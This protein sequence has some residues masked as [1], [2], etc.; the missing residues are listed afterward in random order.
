MKRRRFLNFLAFL[1]TAVFSVALTVFLN[2]G[3]NRLPTAIESMETAEPGSDPISVLHI[4]DLGACDVV[5]SVNYTPDEFLNPINDFSGEIIDIRKEKNLASRG[6]FKF[7]IANLDP[8]DEAFQEKADALAPFLSGDTYWHFTLYLP[9]CFSACA[10]YINSILTETIGEI[11]DYDY[12]RYSDYQKRT[13]RHVS[14]TEPIY[15][16]LSF[17]PKRSVMSPNASDRIKTVTIHYET[18]EGKLSGYQQYPLIGQESE[19][20]SILRR[21]TILTADVSLTAAFVFIIFFFISI[22][23]KM[24]SFIP[25]LMN[26]G[27]LFLYFFTLFLSSSATQFPYLLA[28][29]SFVSLQIIAL[30]AI[31]SQ[32]IRFRNVP[33]WIPFAAFCGI[34]CVISFLQPYR[35]SVPIGQYLSVS[36]LITAVLIVAFSLI[37]V[38]TERDKKPSQLITPALS[39][40][41]IAVYSFRSEFLLLLFNPIVWLCI[42]TLSVTIVFGFVYIVRIEQHSIYLTNNLQSEVARQTDSLQNVINEKNEL[43]QYLS[44]DMKKNVQSMQHFIGIAREHEQDEEQKKTMDIILRKAE[45]VHGCLTELAKYAKQ[46]FTPEK[47]TEFNIGEVLH[48]L[49]EDLRP[50]CDANDVQL[51]CPPANIVVFAKKSTLSAVLQNLIFNALEHANCT[52]IYINASRKK[53]ICRISVT[54]DGKG[55]SADTAVFQAYYSEG[56]SDENL[57]LGLYICRQGIRSMGGELYLKQSPGR[58]SFILTLPIV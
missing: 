6:T 41:L 42:L 31:V 29:L 27:G 24:P 39:A 52:H 37:T 30:S 47:P 56:G 50:D 51:Q 8:Q 9:P 16:D 44:H 54:D 40:V 20:Q 21:N 36:N 57:G 58:T 14:V 10:V 34:N 46:T 48:A 26:I 13:V 35:V 4:S 23:K 1:I 7:F 2:W 45:T 33:V 49:E 15:L 22:L 17:Y 3:V 38:F 12:I 53:N 19:I 43:L 28:A 55:I 18:E 25:R 11:S 32:R 5:R